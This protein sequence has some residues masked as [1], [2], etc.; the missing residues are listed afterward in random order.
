[1]FSSIVKSIRNLL[2][3]SVAGSFDS[4][5]TVAQASGRRVSFAATDQVRSIPARQ[6]PSLQDY[7]PDGMIW[8]KDRSYSFADIEHNYKIIPKKKD[9]EGTILEWDA[10][11]GGY[12]QIIQNDVELVQDWK[13]YYISL[14]HKLP[15]AIKDI[16]DKLD[17]AGPDSLMLPLE[18]DMLTQK[19]DRY[20]QVLNDIPELRANKIKEVIDDSLPLL[21][22]SMDYVLTR[23]GN[24]LRKT[25]TTPT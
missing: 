22:E 14:S 6:P 18:R 21:R 1:M 20:N 19:R 23:Y 3:E 15:P 5:A 9:R 24:H 7:L 11:V 8:K 10:V 16:D 25:A 2:P 4:S 17:A 13:K 12:L